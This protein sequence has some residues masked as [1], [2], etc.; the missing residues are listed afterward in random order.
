MTTNYGIFSLSVQSL[1]WQLKNLFEE[2]GGADA[3]RT[4]DELSTLPKG[5]Q[6]NLLTAFERIIKEVKSGALTLQSVE[7]QEEK[8]AKELEASL[9]SS[10]HQ[11]ISKAKFAVIDGGK[12]KPVN[13]KI[14]AFPTSARASKVIDDKLIA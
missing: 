5:V 4:F 10:I 2:V 9:L 7:S 12:C 11:D 13:S 6:K 3:V 8:T 14:V 1:E